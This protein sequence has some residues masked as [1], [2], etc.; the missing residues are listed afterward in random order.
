[1]TAQDPEA[2]LAQLSERAA[3]RNR[4]RADRLGRLCADLEPGTPDEMWIEGVELAHQIAGSTGTFGNM[5]AS[6]R[7]RELLEALQARDRAA[8]PGLMGAL[9]AALEAAPGGGPEQL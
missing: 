1:M 7:A 4:Q 6:G 9:R 2:V 5:A 3:H 8:V